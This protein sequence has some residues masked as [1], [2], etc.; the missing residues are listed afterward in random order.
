MKGVAGGRVVA[1]RAQRSSCHYEVLY[2]Q[3]CKRD[4]EVVNAKL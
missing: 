3:N 4:S 1:C 2:I